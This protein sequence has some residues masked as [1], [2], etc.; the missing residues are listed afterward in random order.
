M[1][2]PTPTSS[3]WSSTSTS[4][5]P[6]RTPRSRG[7]SSAASARSSLV[8]NKVDDERRENESWGFARLG[9]GDAASG[10][11]DPRAGERR[12]PRR[13]GRGASRPAGRGRRRRE[14]RRRHLL[15]RDRRPPQRRQ[16]DAVQ[17]HRR[18]RALDRARPARHH[19]RRGR[20]GGRDRGRSAAL[21]RHR[22]D[23]SPQQDRRAHRVLLAWCARCRPS[24]APTPRSS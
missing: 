8:A 1:R 14:G 16:V 9:L 18:R 11:G 5:S 22:G 3:S 20:H 24:T 4:A 17:P 19:P 6:R 13:A 15:H 12:S 21:R 7:S 10:V 2:W 23:A